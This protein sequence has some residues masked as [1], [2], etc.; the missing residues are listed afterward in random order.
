M[1]IESP[2]PELKESLTTKILLFCY[3]GILLFCGMGYC[4]GRFLVG[5][6]VPGVNHRLAYY[7]SETKRKLASLNEPIWLHAVSGGEVLAAQSLIE[8]FQHRFPNQRW[9]I[10][11]VTPTGQIVA[12]KFLRKDKGVVLY[13][14]W[15]FTPII[16]RAIRT[17]R[18]SLFLVLETELWPVLFHE[19]GQRN[20]PIFVVNGRI[21]PSAYKRYLLA[22]PVFHRILTPVT[23]FLTQSLQDARRY[24]GIGAA[25]DRIVVTGNIKWD[26]QDNEEKNSSSGK[27]SLRNL[28]GL[29]EKSLLWTAGSTHPGEEESIL[30]VYQKLKTRGAPL[31]LLIAPRHPERVEE[32]E[33]KVQSIGLSSIRRTAL[34]NGKSAFSDESVFLLD[35]LG[36]LATFYAVS[37]LVFVGGS[38]TPNGGHNLVEPAAF[39]RPILT[40]SHLQ[41]FQA[42]A[43]SL[44]SAGGMVIV[45]S[46]EELEEGVEKLLREPAL[47]KQLGARARKVI[48]DH[49]GATERTVQFILRRWNPEGWHGTGVSA[50][51]PEALEGQRPNPKTPDEQS[52]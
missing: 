36:E 32:V 15:D 19:M 50:V 10:T 18:P 22:R 28:L 26:V 21:S 27:E 48:Q 23:A 42:I 20:I 6:R 34:G 7:S 31:R 9:V 8:Q 3:Q 12:Q 47:R 2:I 25:K 52:V 16:R 13:L 41:N 14:P 45:R 35:T 33:R 30:Q 4:A 24:A 51:R 49:R 38:L 46:A 17:I 43:E 1:S 11:T 5:K 39:S 37:D 29:T 40:G 44:S